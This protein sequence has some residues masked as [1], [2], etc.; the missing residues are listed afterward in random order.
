M[1]GRLKT[2]SMARMVK[3]LVQ[4]PIYIEDVQSEWFKDSPDIMYIVE[5]MKVLKSASYNGITVD[6]ISV[7]SESDGKDPD[8]Y[9]DLFHHIME[10]TGEITQSI[11]DNLIGWISWLKLRDSMGEALELMTSVDD[12]ASFPDIASKC[13]LL[14]ENSQISSRGTSKGMDF[15]NIDCHHPD[16]G[17]YIPSMWSMIPKGYELGTLVCYMGEA[18]IG[19]SIFLCNEAVSTAK[20]GNDVLIA[21][22][23]MSEQRIASRLAGSIL[24][25]TDAEY[26][27]LVATDRGRLKM[28]LNDAIDRNYGHIK[29]K[30]FPT[31]VGTVEDI[32]YELHKMRDKGLN[33]KKV[34]VDYL[35]IMA[36]RNRRT[37]DL[38]EKLKN[39]TE[40]LRA[41]AIE[42]QVVVVTA[43]QINRSGFGMDEIGF[44]SIAECAA[45]LHTCDTILAITQTE[46]FRAANLYRLKALKIRDGAG[47]GLSTNVNIDYSH[48][49]L[50][51]D[52][53][54]ARQIIDQLIPPSSGS[55]DSGHT[56][57]FSS[58]DDMLGEFD[59]PFEENWGASSQQM[60]DAFMNK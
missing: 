46:D 9:V 15:F 59:V 12:A 45:I 47:K 55:L 1:L 5:I 42:E 7:I 29:I 25:L 35:G 52:A 36:S 43:G 39:I 54:T 17:K 44:D 26:S 8:F 58:N 41:L 49:K 11:A 27:N 23:E 6:D 60:I 2:T 24:G 16:E 37:T 4:T 13:R 14:I 31:S 40:E 10:D 32:R 56:L 19:K 28:L 53:S 38:Y 21:S 22:F 57:E 33:P 34:V 48:M 3:F 51:E 50:S 18:N 30:Q 20:Q